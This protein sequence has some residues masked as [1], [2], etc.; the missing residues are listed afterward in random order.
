MTRNVGGDLFCGK[1]GDR[2]VAG[3][4]EEPF[5]P[6]CGFPRCVSSAPIPDLRAE[7]EQLRRENER[8]RGVLSHALSYGELG[9]QTTRRLKEAL[10]PRA[11]DEGQ[12]HG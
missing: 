11:S 5:C 6:T 7:V 1:C 3:W 8:L 4:Q 12:A 2:L 10:N 9:K